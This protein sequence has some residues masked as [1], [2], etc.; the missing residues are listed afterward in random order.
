MRVVWLTRCVTRSLMQVHRVRVGVD[1][2]FR[3]GRVHY[4]D[5]VEVWRAGWRVGGWE[6]QRSRRGI[7]GWCIVMVVGAGLSYL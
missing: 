5:W 1:L 2:V 7:K 6:G 4:G 3:G